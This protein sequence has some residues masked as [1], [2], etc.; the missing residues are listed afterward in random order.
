MLQPLINFF[1]SFPP[2]VATVLI[3]MT[4][5]AELR[6]SLPLAILAFKMPI[7]QAIMF[8]IIGNAIPAFVISLFGERFHKWVSKK[9]GLFAAKWIKLLHRAHKKFS[10]DYEKYGLIGLMIFI[11]IPLPGTG[12]W[13][14][15]LGALVFGIPFRKSW[16]YILGGIIIACILTLLVTIWADQLF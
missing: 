1:S 10:G 6:L 15:S 11:G 9:S 16:P 4:P 3:A 12:A 13:T 5:V 14:G 8:S 2:E 7:W